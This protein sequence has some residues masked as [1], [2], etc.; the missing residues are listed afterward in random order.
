MLGFK[1]AKSDQSLFVPN[2]NLSTIMLAYTRVLHARIKHIELDL[3]FARE[4]VMQKELEVHHVQSQDQIADVLIKAI[5][6]S[7][8]PA[9]RHKLRVEDLSTSLLLQ[10]VIKLLKRT[11]K[12]RY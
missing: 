4:K 11:R 12:T 7:N 5:S 3:Y 2:D 1:S 9:L 6:T 8:F 10:V